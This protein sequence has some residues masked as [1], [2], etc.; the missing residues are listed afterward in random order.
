MTFDW[1]MAFAMGCGTYGAIV[2]WALLMHSLM[3]ASS[4]L[5]HKT[6]LIGPIPVFV[7]VFIFGG[8]P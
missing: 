2:L 1:F 7:V 5:D 8:L 6:I 3:G 4:K